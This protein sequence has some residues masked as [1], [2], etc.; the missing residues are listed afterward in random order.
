MNASNAHLY[1][2]TSAAV[3]GRRLV[4]SARMAEAATA[5][6]FSTSLIA[7][8]RAWWRGGVS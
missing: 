7:E 6:R 5:R 8:C 3:F 4:L 2:S 1:L